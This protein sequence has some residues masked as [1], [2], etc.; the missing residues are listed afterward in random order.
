MEDDLFGKLSDLEQFLKRLFGEELAL[1]H[2]LLD[3][4]LLQTRLR[5]TRRLL[6]F[7]TG[8]GLRW[9]VSELHPRV[10]TAEHSRFRPK[11]ERRCN[12][13]EKYH[14]VNNTPNK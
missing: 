5:K 11:R 10:E 1:L 4:A 7:R 14:V 9:R 13:A 2:Q 8:F 6:L 3:V 12:I